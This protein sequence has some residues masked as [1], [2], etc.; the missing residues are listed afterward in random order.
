MKKK[1]KRKLSVPVIILIMV[2]SVWLTYEF[3]RYDIEKYCRKY[4]INKIINKAYQ[5]GVKLCRQLIEIKSEK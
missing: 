1:N 2:V 3:I 5:K 4:K